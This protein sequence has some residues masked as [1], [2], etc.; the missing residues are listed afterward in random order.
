[1]KKLITKSAVKTIIWMLLI[2]G[3]SSGL[4]AS[5]LA[6]LKVLD[7][8]FLIVHFKDGDVKFVDNGKGPTAF[9]GH[10]SDTDN[11]YVVTYGEP[12][13]TDIIAN[14][15]LWRIVS[16][17]DT[18]YG[19]EGLSPVAVFRK[20]R[21]NGMS[22]KG[23]DPGISDHGFDYTTEHFI[24]L[25]LPMSMKQGNN[26]TLKIDEKLG[27]DV[28]ETS[29]KYD[30]FS[31]VSEAV[32]INLV[33]YMGSSGIKAADLYHFTGDGG[34]RDYSDFAGNE[35]FIYDVSSKE[36]H[37]VGRVSFWMKSQTETSWN[38]T[39]SDVWTADFTGF[40]KPGTYR[41]V[42]DGVGA[43]QDF[44]IRDDIYR[45][46]WKV[47]V[48]GYY[49]MRIGE[50]R[51]DMTP[52]PRRPLWIQDVDPPDTKIIITDMHPF[53]SEWR[54]F[55]TGDPWDRPL[56]WVPYV[57]EGSPEN[58]HAKGGH[59][60]ALDWD[61]HLAHVVDIYDLLF[62]YILSNGALD[63]DN[64]RVAESGNG[65]PDVID[66]ARNAVNFWL[67][68]RYKG[69][70]GHGL[71]NPDRNNRLYQAGNT[72]IAA[73]ANALNCA[74]MSFSLQ[75][76]GHHDLAQTYR[77]SSIV[78]FNYAMSSPAP[79]L[80][81]RVEG[82]RGRDFKM[83]AAAYLYNI[84]GDTKYEDIM[85]SECIVTGPGSDIHRQNSH[86]QLWGVAAY[87]LTKQP[88]N[89]PELFE[90]MKSSIIVEADDKEAGFVKKRPSRR[91][92][93]PQQ[94]WWQTNQDMHRTI[95]AHAV[96]SNPE[97]KTS[98]LDALLLEADWG[99]GRNPMN[100]IQMTTATTDLADKRSIENIYTSGRNDGTPGLHP[101]HTPYLN[102]ESWGG[103]MVGSN[104]S[105]VFDKFYYPGITNWPHAEKY[106][107]TRFIWTHSE[108]TPRQT[109][110]GKALLYAYLYGLSKNN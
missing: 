34:N 92:Y 71:T 28:T 88:V 66:E 42:V 23:W 24:Y 48:L 11:S 107:N 59:S 44:E 68:L 108:F 78:A 47:S 64:L 5:K 39:G 27:S 13:N 94:A 31:N 101:G 55:S 67:N 82:V 97:Q 56:D 14:V 84:T 8:D 80:D 17:N 60:D 51:M 40:S 74:M 98:F 43:S 102:T 77:D 19:S 33:G 90:N 2:T 18:N 37:S 106:I 93:A 105:K 72:I 65:I 62:G 70:Y 73:W 52:V 100:K 63:D 95:L 4:Q 104:P 29:V 96:T 21:A 15:G 9:E 103:N 75:I 6:S 38:L 45:V 110:R 76:S 50:D 58:P 36:V 49:Y 32:H 30:N 22:Y 85:K 12:L 41:L 53:H 61:R 26:Y 69:G 46:P 7:R 20:T 54:T 1:M 81:D 89:Y 99:L 16:Q 35:V 83:M 3:I 57:K 79:M 109:M 10:S 86:N 91:G 87:L 25:Q